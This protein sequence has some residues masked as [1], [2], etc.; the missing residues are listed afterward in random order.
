MKISYAITVKDEVKEIRRLITF[1]LENKRAEDEIIVLWDM[2][3]DDSIFNELSDLHLEFLIQLHSSYFKGNF[4]EWKNQLNSECSGDYIFQIDADE[5][6]NISLIK[7]LPEILDFQNEIDLF[8]VS[9]I[10]TVEGI[11]QEHINKWGWKVNKQNWINF[12]DQ[13]TRIYK[14]N[15]DIKWQGNVH[16]RITGFKTYAL[17]PDIEEYCL[18]HPKT[19][20]RQEK[21]N[22]YYN[23]L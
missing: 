2:N 21:Q 22:N 9:R 15:P 11:T 19:I 17:L 3:G 1:L 13:Q 6:P 18:Y 8:I 23:T 12:P 14:N 4:A 20:E 7:A 16:E 5:I 10:N